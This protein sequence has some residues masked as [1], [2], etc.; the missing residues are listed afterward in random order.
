MVRVHSR[1]HHHQLNSVMPPVE[2]VRMGISRNILGL[3]TSY[4]FILILDLMAKGRGS[5]ESLSYFP[6]GLPSHS[7]PLT[8]LYQSPI[9]LSPNPPLW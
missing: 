5:S 8:P 7:Q 3:S 1:Y 4:L 2:T 6:G 9:M